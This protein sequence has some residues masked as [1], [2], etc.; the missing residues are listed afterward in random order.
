[1]K[2]LLTQLW[3]TLTNTSEQ[4]LGLGPSAETRVPKRIIEIQI[5]FKEAPKAER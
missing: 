3:E 1:M 5:F 4:T 2:H